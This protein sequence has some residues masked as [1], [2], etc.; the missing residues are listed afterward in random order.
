[1]SAKNVFFFDAAPRNLLS[2]LLEDISLL[3][4]PVGLLTDINEKDNNI[5]K[6]AKTNKDCFLTGPQA[7]NIPLKK[8]FPLGKTHIKKCFFS[9]RTTKVFP[10]Y[11]NG[12]VVHVTFFS[13][14][15]SLIIA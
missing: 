8:Y 10:P 7:L 11:T 1:M 13:F 2:L 6:K 4:G 12:L 5:S 3:K 14:F 15:F 9:G